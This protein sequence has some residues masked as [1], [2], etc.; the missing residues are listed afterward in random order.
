MRRLL[1][2]CLAG[3]VAGSLGGFLVVYLPNAFAHVPDFDSETVLSSAVVGLAVGGPFGIVAFPA[4]YYLFLTSMPLRLSLAVTFLSAVVVA[5]LFEILP[6]YSA[7]TTY[8]G[9]SWYLAIRAY[10]PAILGLGLSSIALNRLA[11]KS[12]R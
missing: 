7:N 11:P 3:F 6:V 12:V 2:V 4:C 9:W 8:N 10:G 5:V 1:V